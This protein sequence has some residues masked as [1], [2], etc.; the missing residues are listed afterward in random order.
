V[1]A[2]QEKPQ[3]D[4]GWVN[5]GFM[6]LEP[7]FFDYIAGDETPLESEP[8]ERAAQDG[9]L[10][11]FKHE[12]FWQSMDTMRDKSLLDSLWESHQAPWKLWNNEW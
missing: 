9:Q 10:M 8:L 4:G 7:D 12:G 1:A 11:A 6:V 2:F 3:G 5:A